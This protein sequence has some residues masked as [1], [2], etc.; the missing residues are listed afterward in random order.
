LHAP[1]ISYKTIQ[2]IISSLGGTA[3]AL[4]EGNEDMS[5]RMF[6]FSAW[7]KTNPHSSSVLIGGLPN[8]IQWWPPLTHVEVST[9]FR[10]FILLTIW[11]AL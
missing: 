10:T 11:P 4:A 9:A 3:N 2:P 1:C 5:G 7:C 8:S 6:T